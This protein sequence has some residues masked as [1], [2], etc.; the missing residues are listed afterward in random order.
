MLQGPGRQSRLRRFAADP[1]M[2]AASTDGDIERSLDLA[3]ILIECAAEILQPR[4]VQ[5]LQGE[6]QRAG[7]S[8]QDIWSGRS[9]AQG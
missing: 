1:A 2:L 7:R 3:Q 5:R 4:V 6:R 8:V 9:I